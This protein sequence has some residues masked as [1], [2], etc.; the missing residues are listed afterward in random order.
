[1]PTSATILGVERPDCAKALNPHA[2]EERDQVLDHDEYV[3]D[4]IFRLRPDL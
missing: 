3:S 2:P 1:M 4:G